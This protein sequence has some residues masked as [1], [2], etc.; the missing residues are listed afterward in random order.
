M[1]TARAIIPDREELVQSEQYMRASAVILFLDVSYWACALE[2]AP[3]KLAP[4]FQSPLMLCLIH[5]ALQP[6][7]AP[8][9]ASASI[10]KLGI[11][12]KGVHSLLFSAWTARADA[13][14]GQGAARIGVIYALAAEFSTIHNH[15][16]HTPPG[17][18]WT[19][20]T[21][22][23]KEIR[24]KVQIIYKVKYLCFLYEKLRNGPSSV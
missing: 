5:S 10:L 4:I 11:L 19:P 24:R 23:P 21:W 12:L 13:N 3:P 20:R 7:N 22:T 8:E 6:A 17:W 2:L 18:T 14:I 1:C 15:R 16:L 9:G